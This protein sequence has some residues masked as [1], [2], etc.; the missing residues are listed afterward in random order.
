MFTE[1]LKNVTQNI[2]RLKMSKQ[3]LKILIIIFILPHTL[4]AQEISIKELKQK[5]KNVNKI[6]KLKNGYEILTNTEAFYTFTN[7]NK[8]SKLP[9]FE[10]DA[11]PCGEVYRE[12]YKI[13]K[14]NKKLFKYKIDHKES[15]G[16]SA[17]SFLKVYY[18][19]GIPKNIDSISFLDGEKRY[20]WSE[21]S[22]FFGKKK[23]YPNKIIVYNNNKIGL[24]SYDINKKQ[25]LPEKKYRKGDLIPMLEEKFHIK[26]VEELPLSDIQIKY[27]DQEG[28]I[29]VVNKNSIQFLFDN[30]PRL[31]E[32]SEKITHSFY[33]VYKDDKVG[34]IDISENKEYGL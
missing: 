10:P 13:K 19:K 16:Y 28:V 23:G 21:N 29:K 4:Y 2:T 26:L 3:N 31:Y 27:D 5:F 14:S 6:H 1:L 24:Y 20:S 17:D 9:A 7:G 22:I 32:K 15:F 34:F 18:L 12:D 33:K 30:K 8:V 25:K 11:Y